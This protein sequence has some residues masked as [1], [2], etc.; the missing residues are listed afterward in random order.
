MAITIDT[1]NEEW[2]KDS[3]DFRTDP[4]LSKHSRN[5]L[6]LHQK[7]YSMLVKTVSKKNKLNSMYSE[8]KSNKID[9]YSGEMDLAKM[10]ELGW[11]PYG[12]RLVKAEV[13]KVVDSDPAIIAFVEGMAE[14]DNCIRYL[15][16]IVKKLNQRSFDIKNIIEYEKFVSGVA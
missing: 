9:Y 15:E 14:I 13:T 5:Q 6:S 1:I 4:D 10:K 16:D 8:L 11:P 3:E 7:Y 2:A 12:K